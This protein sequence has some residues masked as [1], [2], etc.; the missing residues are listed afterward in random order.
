MRAIHSISLSIALGVSL[1]GCGK[2]PAPPPPTVTVAKPTVKRIVEYSEYTGRLAAR[3]NVEVRPRVSGYIDKIAFKEGALVNKGDL[4]FM[5]DPRPYQ[6][7]LDQAA[8]QLKQA[9]AQK[10]LS[11]RNFARAQTLQATKVSS[12]EEFDQAATARNQSEAQ[13]ASAQA[14]V[15]AAK[16][17]LDF[18]QIH[19][20]ISGRISRQ[21]VN[22]G[23][24]V[25]SDST[26]L[27]N[28]VSVDPIYAYADVDERTVLTYQQLIKEGKVKSARTSELPIALALAGE[29]GFPH[30]GVIDFVDNQ[31]NAATGTLQIRGRF[32]NTDGNLLA[33]MFVRVRIPVSQEFDALLITDRAVGSDQGQKFVY[34]VN[35]GKAERRAVVLG[36]KSDGLRVAAK[37]LQPGDE[38]IINGL[39]KVR[40]GATVKTEP[41]KMEQFAANQLESGVTVGSPGK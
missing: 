25:M 39:M 36:Q 15:N 34:V 22:A 20:P 40:P 27:T 33:G 23:N 10:E 32:P 17:N 35:Q 14:A 5:I 16:L 31:I 28:I 12:K 18:T 4:L 7:S 3:E 19:A 8:G 9:E 13:V 24:L 11:E 21:Q 41:G 29:Q 26:L 30:D 2:P 38:V 1:S 37:G 6:A